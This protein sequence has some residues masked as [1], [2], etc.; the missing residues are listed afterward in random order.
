MRGRCWQRV[1]GLL[2]TLLLAG[3]ASTQASV[4]A[5]GTAGA[6][7]G[8]N[9]FPN[10]KLVTHEGQEVRFFDDLVKGKIVV[11]NFIYTTCTEV[12]PLDTASLRNVQEILGDRVGRDVFMYS[13]SIDPD[14]DTPEALA[15][16]AQRYRVGPGWT[17]LTGAKADT[18]LLR[19]KLGLYIEGLEDELDHN[20]SFV[21]GNQRTGRWLKRSPMDNPHF[22]AQQ[23][24][25]WADNWRTPG[26]IQKNAYADAP[27]LEP[28]SMGE[29]LFRTRCISCHSIGNPASIRT[30]GHNPAIPMA[31][32]RAGPDLLHITQK[33]DHRWLARWLASPE[34]LIAERD[35]IALELYAKYD[36]L[37]MPNLQL[38]DVEVNALIEYM[39]AE[40]RR[41]QESLDA[42]PNGKHDSS[43]HHQHHHHDH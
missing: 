42:M 3:A 21:I 16:Y 18:L 5:S 9:Y 4:G 36:G 20:M 39:S 30:V 14:R 24:A 13:I 7:W 2:C 19:K 41:V 15:K 22:I 32:H 31:Q 38:N 8:A 40:S 10:V 17:F 34:A 29:N 6:R 28:P 25:G 1:A 12:C 43:G 27:L 23:I 11:I 35:P 33:R 37:V 26:G